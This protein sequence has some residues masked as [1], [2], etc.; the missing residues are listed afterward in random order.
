[1]RPYNDNMKQFRKVA[2]AI[3]AWDELAQVNDRDSVL[4]RVCLHTLARTRLSPTTAA[5][6]S[7]Q[8]PLEVGK[9]EQRVRSILRS[10]PAFVQPYRGRWQVGA[11]IVRRA[12]EA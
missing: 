2:P 5:E 12:I 10:N 4:A 8:L 1:M 7:R 3:P 9:N 6:L 11:A